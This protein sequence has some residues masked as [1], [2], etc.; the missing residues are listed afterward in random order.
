MVA[1][2]D[3]LQSRLAGGEWVHIFPEGTRSRDGR[4]L[5]VR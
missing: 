2:L 5:P 1:F 4:M 3:L